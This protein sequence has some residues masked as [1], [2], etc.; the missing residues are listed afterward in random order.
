MTTCHFFFLNQIMPAHQ[1]LAQKSWKL[2]YSASTKSEIRYSLEGLTRATVKTAHYRAELTLASSQGTTSKATCPTTS[3]VKG[4][5]Y[6]MIQFKIWGPTSSFQR[7]Y[8]EVNCSIRGEQNT[9]NS[10][11]RAK[12]CSVIMIYSDFQRA[13]DDSRWECTFEYFSINNTA[14]VP[15]KLSWSTCHWDTAF[16]KPARFCD[17]EGTLL[18]IWS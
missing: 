18:I 1:L 4:N 12:Q 9:C 14:C 8:I 13:E 11:W 17:L 7:P 10:T 5:R 16:P 15:N 3:L 2:K 6:L